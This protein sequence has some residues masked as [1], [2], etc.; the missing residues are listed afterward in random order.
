MNRLL[1]IFI[2][3]LFPVLVFAQSSVKGFK[4]FEK[5]EYDKAVETFTKH[6]QDDTASCAA[7]FGLALTYSLENYP[8]HDYF[9][10]CYNY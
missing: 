9:K 1:S 5:G 7:Y 4:S 10:C 6:L 8:N 3:S 2:I